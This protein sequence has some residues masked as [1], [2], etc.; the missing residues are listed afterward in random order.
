MQFLG[1]AHNKQL[2]GLLKQPRDYFSL[3]FPFA[4]RARAGRAYAR[5][6]PSALRRYSSFI[7]NQRALRA[8]RLLFEEPT[9][10]YSFVT[11][12]SCFL[13]FS[14][15]DCPASV[16]CVGTDDINDPRRIASV[17]PAHCAA[18]WKAGAVAGCSISG[19]SPTEIARPSFLFRLRAFLRVSSYSFIE[20]RFTAL[21]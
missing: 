11:E 17:C 21:H 19:R 3:L 7:R 18:L 13:S 5:A 20:S 16:L 12:P 9:V 15:S 14:L 10:H 1:A 6:C 2:F 8:S 4:T